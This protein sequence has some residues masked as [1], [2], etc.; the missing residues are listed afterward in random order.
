MVTLPEKDQWSPAA[1]PVSFRRRLLAAGVVLVATVLAI[2]ALSGSGEDAAEIPVV[3]A[4]ERWVEGHPPGEHVTMSMPADL[5]ALFTDPSELDS[6]VVT[7]DVPEG[8]LVSP[9]MLRPRPDDNNR[10]TALIRIEANHEMWSGA[11]PYPGA[12][13]VFAGTPGGCAVALVNLV[14]TGTDGSDSSVTIEADPEL[15]AVLAGEQWWI[16]ESPPAGWPRCEPATYRD[17]LQVPCEP[18]GAGCR[19]EEVN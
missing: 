16:W 7:T 2:V 12:R 18:G 4:A 11:G 5:A 1:W 17:A 15:A 6:T 14:A 9:A 3:A 8:T 10:R 19:V 13:A